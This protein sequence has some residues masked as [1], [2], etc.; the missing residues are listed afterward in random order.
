MSKPVILAIDD[1]PEVLAAIGRDLRSQYGETYRIMRAASGAEAL[2]AARELKT[3][4]APVALF[5]ADQRMPG[6]TGTEF[7]AQARALHP[8]ARRVLLTAYADT[9][10][11]IESINTVGLDHYLMKPWHPPDERL[12]PVLDDLLDEWSARVRLPYEGIRVAGATW[13][14]KSYAV[15]EFLSRNQV[16]YQWLDAEEDEPTRAL[17]S[18]LVDDPTRLPVVLFP[19]GTHLVEPDARALADKVGL[20]T[21]A[22]RP[23]YDLV[24]VG[25]GPAGLAVAVYGASE[26]LRTLLVECTAPGGQAGTSSLIE[27]YLGFPNGL[28]GADLTRRATAQAQRFGAEIVSAQRVVGVRRE[29]PYRVV[30]MAD[31]SEVSCYCVLLTSGLSVRKLDVPGH[32][33]LLGIGVYYGAAMTEAT[34]CRGKPV[35]V[36]GGANSAGQGAMFFSKYA[37]AVQMIVRKPGLSPWMSKYLVDRIEKTDN[38]EVVAEAEVCEFQ[39]ERGLERVVVRRGGSGERTALEAAAAFIFIGA[40]PRSEMVED[41]VDRDD[42][43]FILTGPDLPRV[44]GRPRGWTLDRDP[45]LLETNVP[46]VFAAGD[47]RFGSSR[48]VAGAV[49]EGSASLYMVHKYLLTV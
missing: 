22:T 34:V 18:G 26:G 36:I 44:H 32:D 9:D 35:C 2:D 14:A 16:P 20:R 7:L 8:D 25:A 4:G 12:Y 21:K 5:L 49:G 42:R 43:G 19:D 48:R 13:S 30:R 1:D 29:D 11:A 40:A 10:A 46:G 23:F 38:I 47:V 37:S 3:R 33:A 31:G 6:M 24:V 39:G 15:K 41:L 27:N 45:F 28:S 17:L